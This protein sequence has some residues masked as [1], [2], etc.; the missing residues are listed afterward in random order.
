MADVKST[1]LNTELY[2]N[3]VNNGIYRYPR[4]Y[5]TDI[6]YDN[7]Q[8]TVDGTNYINIIITG[9]PD[10]IS[11]I[12]NEALIS[13]GAIR[14]L[15]IFSNTPLDESH[16]KTI[17]SIYGKI[18]YPILTASIACGHL[19]EYPKNNFYLCEGVPSV[20]SE[21]VEY[22]YLQQRHL[23]SNIAYDSL[24]GSIYRMILPERPLLVI[25]MPNNFVRTGLKE[26]YFRFDNNIIIRVFSKYI[27]SSPL[28]NRNDS[29]EVSVI[30]TNNYKVKTII[31]R[32]FGRLGMHKITSNSENHIYGYDKY[33]TMVVGSIANIILP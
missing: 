20:I 31:E 27:L 19:T 10:E 1:G 8:L 24:T 26:G 5:Q 25:I 3:L 14:R 23:V 30:S 6:T 12:A 13:K 28:E 17:D 33:M 9:I 22:R 18:P 11:P 15:Y 16:L 7:R 21:F 4:M 2:T 29:N 32:F